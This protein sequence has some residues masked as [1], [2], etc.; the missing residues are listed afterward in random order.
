MP[1][2]ATYCAYLRK[3][4]AD[5]EAEA[6][7]EGETLLRHKTVLSTLARRN[8]HAITQWYQEIVSGETISA[9]PEMQCLLADV[10]A[11]KWAGVYVMEVERLARGDTADQGLV[12]QAFKYS[13]TRIITPNKT[14]DPSNEFDEEYFEFS[15]FMSRREYKTINRRIQAG[16]LQSIREGKYIC[17]RPAYGYRK[18]KLENEKGYTLKIDETEAEVIRQIFKWYI[19]GDQ[20]ERMGLTRIAAR[21]SDLRVPTGEQ[22]SAWKPCRI[23]R[24]LTNE[25]YIG[26]IRWGRVRT[27]RGLTGNGI[28]KRLEMTNDYELHDG[29]HE[30]IIDEETFARA[31]AIAKSRTNV[32]V[33][34]DHEI[35]N[36]LIGILVCKECGHVMRGKPASGRQDA[37]VFCATR[38]CPTVRTYRRPVEDAILETLRAWLTK[39]EADVSTMPAPPAKAMPSLEEEAIARLNAELVVLKAQKDRLHDLLEQGV[40]TVEV[41]AERQA[42]VL[43]KIADVERSLSELRNRG[44]LEYVPIAELAPEIRHVLDAYDAAASAAEKNALLRSVVS[45]VEYSKSVRGVVNHGEVKVAGDQFL[46]TL[47]PRLKQKQ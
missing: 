26:K 6:R 14:Y 47:Y 5:A 39:Y 43:E 44:E 34:K 28:E 27:R 15:L 45:K 33:R 46:L 42:V 4:R 12:A 23:H 8:K 22:G 17:S 16:R 37:Q 19:A 41:F 11:G 32:P 35:S 24:I 20:G 30:A 9:R 18:V 36:P 7:G 2:P 38:G 40:Y 13:N 3:S 1:D 31:Q 29:L 10:G 21:L 25:V